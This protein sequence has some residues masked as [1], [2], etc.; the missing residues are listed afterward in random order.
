MQRSVFLTNTIIS[1][2]EN[3]KTGDA[4]IN[5]NSRKIMREL[6]TESQR[7]SRLPNGYELKSGDVLTQFCFQD[8]PLFV[9]HRPLFKVNQNDEKIMEV[10]SS[11][12]F[13]ILTRDK[14]FFVKATASGLAAVLWEGV[15]SESDI[16]SKLD[17]PDPNRTIP[18]TVQSPE[19]T[20][21]EG[22]MTF[23]K[24]YNNAR[25][26]HEKS[27]QEQIIWKPS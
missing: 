11:Y 13:Q 14:A 25:A 4:E 2:L 8:K 6:I 10:A 17:Y 21:T 9:L 26:A 23:A 16:N 7:L 12:N 19:N 18:E 24:A 20:Q 22:E 5:I 27:I 15:E 1:E 3:K